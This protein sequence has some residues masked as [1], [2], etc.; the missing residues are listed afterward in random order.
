[1]KK[2]ILINQNSGYLTIDIANAFASKYTKVSLIAGIVKQMERDLNRNVHIN[3]II[4][5]N[6]KSSILRIFTW[7]WGSIQIFLLLL[8]KYRK[9]DVVYFTNPP[10]A[11]LSSLLL[12]NKFSIIVYDTYPDALKNIGINENS[13][14]Y[15]MWSKWNKKLFKRAEKIIALSNGM[16][17]QLSSYVEHTKIRVIPNWSGSDKFSPIKKEENIFIQKHNLVGKFIVLYSGNMGLTHNVETI[18]E[19]AKVLESNDHIRFLFIGEG[20]KKE[21]LQKL[22]TFYNLS[23]CIFLT[24]QASNVL[25]HSLAS[26]DLSVITINKESANLSVPSKTYNLLAVGSPLLCIA[27]LH[28]ELDLLVKRYKNGRCFESDNIIEIAHFIMSLSENQDMQREFSQNSISA[29]SD[30]HYSNALKYL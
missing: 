22:C 24:W 6:R 15:R 10:M 21:K 23:N 11:Y 16:A 17:A 27:P 18:I 1:M 29:A 30:F 13:V 20:D 2:I 28:S 14:I 3:K 7:G 25:P 4:K 5:L 12:K 26:A 19:I 9:Y 8:I